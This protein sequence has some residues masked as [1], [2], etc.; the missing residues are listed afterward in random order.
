MTIPMEY[1]HAS[2]EFEAFMSEFVALADLPTHHRAYHSIRA[3]IHVF[4]SHLP[5]KEALTFANVLPPVLCAIFVEDWQPAEEPLPFPHRKTL[6][7]EIKSIRSDHKLAP[8]TVMEDAA[9][10]MCGSSTAFWLNCLRTRL[11]SGPRS[12]PRTIFTAARKPAMRP[13]LHV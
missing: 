12:E 1:A 4:R 2:K 10:W 8:E 9:M 11:V 7:R 6:L 13:A 3:V 5:V